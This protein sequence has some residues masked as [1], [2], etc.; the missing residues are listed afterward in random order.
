MKKELQVIVVV[1]VILSVYYMA[2]LAA[3]P[4]LS[5]NRLLFSGVA[6]W[7]MPKTELKPADSMASVEDL[8][9]P[10]SRRFFENAA[11]KGFMRDADNELVAIFD[12]PGF[13]VRLLKAGMSFGGLTVLSIDGRSCKV[14][15]GSVIQS[16]SL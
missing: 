2:Q 15:F 16:L 11:L 14:K 13:D 3:E 1:A 4:P 7:Q 9:S 5:V 8:A 6:S 10:F 12:S